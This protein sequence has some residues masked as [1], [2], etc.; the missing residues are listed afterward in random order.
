MIEPRSRSWLTVAAGVFLLA[1]LAG[2][3]EYHVAPDGKADGAGTRERPWD[4]VSALAGKRGVKA[5]DTLWVHGGTYRSKNAYERKGLGFDVKLAGTADKPIHVRAWKG[6][7]VT[8][9]GGMTVSAPSRF[10][11]LW[12]LEITVTPDKDVS[13]ET[14]KGGSSPGDLGAPLGGLHIYAGEG[15]K[16][17]NLVI[18]DNF[19]S[20]LDWWKG[21]TNSEVYGCIIVNNGW[22]G[23]DRCH[24]HCI[25]TQNAEGTKT[26]SNCIMTTRWGR[27]QYTMHAYGSRRAW[28][29]N[30]VI[31]ENI[32]YGKGT[33]LVGGGR[34]SRNIVV[35]KNYLYQVPMQIGYNAPHNEDCEVRDNIVI[36]GGL[37]VSRYRKAVVCGNLIVRGGMNLS[38][39]QQVERKG[40]RLVPGPAP[41]EARVLLLPN[42]YDRNRAN[43]AVLNPANA[44]RVKVNVAGFLRAGE[45]FRLVRAEDVFG[46]PALT[47]TCRGATLSVPMDAAFGAFVLRK[48]SR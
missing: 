17:I 18:H 43:L 9:D 20:G 23:P 19:G 6:G 1:G 34:P 46:R 42:R 29:D 30:Y 21:S 32:C 45:A 27:G 44:R 24:G 7:R 12:D 37:N 25:Y 15:C 26:I 14:K 2:G 35:R 13:R 10:V 22:R 40:N 28:V 36:R 33:F 31:E 16:F 47:G 8:I 11:W 41:A 48:G 3:A 39:C 38:K 5:G 4:V